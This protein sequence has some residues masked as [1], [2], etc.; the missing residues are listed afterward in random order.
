M[1]GWS[2]ATA[3]ARTPAEIATGTGG[4]TYRPSGA[5]MVPTAAQ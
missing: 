4:P 1:E 5:S 3:G 2:E